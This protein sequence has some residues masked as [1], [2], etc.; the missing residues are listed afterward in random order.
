MAWCIYSGIVDYFVE[1]EGKGIYRIPAPKK[2]ETEKQQ[3]EA[4]AAP[5]MIEL[6]NFIAY[7]KLLFE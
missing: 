4:P 3:E 2:E 6:K 5:T 1:T 7:W